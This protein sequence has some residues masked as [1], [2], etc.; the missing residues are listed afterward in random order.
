MSI[1]AIL[2]KADFGGNRGL[3]CGD[4]WSTFLATDVHNLVTGGLPCG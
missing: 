3:I 4:L 2:Y 1:N